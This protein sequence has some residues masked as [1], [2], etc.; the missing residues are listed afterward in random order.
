MSKVYMFPTAGNSYIE[1]PKCKG[2]IRYGVTL[3]DMALIRNGT[4]EA[5]KVHCK[6]GNTFKI[7]YKYTI[8]HMDNLAITGKTF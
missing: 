5:S 6:C 2:F 1:C 8:R 3:E 7:Y 4:M